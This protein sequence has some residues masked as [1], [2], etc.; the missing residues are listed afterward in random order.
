MPSN[1][2]SWNVATHKALIPLPQIY[3]AENLAIY[4]VHTTSKQILACQC[5]CLA[6]VSIWPM[7][8]F[9]SNSNLTNAYICQQ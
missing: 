4:K 7:H 5:K 6:I 9:A 8:I 3:I 1:I 2:N